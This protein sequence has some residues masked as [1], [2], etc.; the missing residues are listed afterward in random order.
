M[1]LIDRLAQFNMN[2]NINPNDKVN[3]R[4]TQGIYFRY[5][6]TAENNNN[7]YGVGS[8]AQ[9]SKPELVSENNTTEQLH[10]TVDE[11]LQVSIDSE[12][13]NYN[14]SLGINYYP[15]DG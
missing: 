6:S 5:S 11:T 12:V 14:G 3:I 7:I 10:F 15:L 1:Q 9:F 13:Q 2:L 8:L 4:F